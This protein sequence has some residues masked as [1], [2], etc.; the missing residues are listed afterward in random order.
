MSTYLP[1]KLPSLRK[2]LIITLGGKDCHDKPTWII[3]DPDSGQSFHIGY[4]EYQMLRRW[5]LMHPAKIVVE[6]N[7]SSQVTITEDDVKNFYSFLYHQ[8]L[9]EASFITS[10]KF[11]KWKMHIKPKWFIILS[12]VIIVMM[13]VGALFIW[14]QDLRIPATIQYRN[15]I[16]T[17]PEDAKLIQIFVKNG[18]H[19]KKDQVLAVLTSPPLTHQLHETQ[20]KIKLLYWQLRVLS[21]QKQDQTKLMPLNQALIIQLEKKANIKYHINRL[22]L[23]APFSGVITDLQM[24]LHH[25]RW[26][27]K[28]KMLMSIINPNHVIIKGHATA[29]ERTHIRIYQ[30]GT[31]VPKKLNHPKV[32]GIVTKISRSESQ[33]N[34]AITLRPNQ[35]VSLQHSEEGMLFLDK[36]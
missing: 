1:E 12:T 25:N 30:V 36:K 11:F 15:T 28:D 16:I 32:H 29:M 18:Q 21:T 3:H 9:L 4:Q 19:V 22:T 33:A 27:K 26:L 17:S 7:Q 20:H 24:G 13:I 10:V 35:P 34:Y 5:N 14:Q 6:V 8:N 2:E 23:R 31:F